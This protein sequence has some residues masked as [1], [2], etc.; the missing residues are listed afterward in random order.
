MQG[1]RA[2]PRTCWAHPTAWYTSPL[3]SLS[4]E[5][6]QWD[7]AHCCPNGYCYTPSKHISGF[8]ARLEP[9]SGACCSPT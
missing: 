1:R 9:P 2:W 7:A 3:R 5:V 4:W 8:S 6:T